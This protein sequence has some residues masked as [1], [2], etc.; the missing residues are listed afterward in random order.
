MYVCMYCVYSIMYYIHP[1][2]LRSRKSL[3]YGTIQ[4]NF[5]KKNILYYCTIGDTTAAALVSRDCCCTCGDHNQMA[6]LS[7]MY[8]GVNGEKKQDLFFNKLLSI[9][10][11]IPVHCGRSA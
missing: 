7:Q 9:G 5:T 4:F 1:F 8:V 2:V 3:V 11:V 10:T 6:L